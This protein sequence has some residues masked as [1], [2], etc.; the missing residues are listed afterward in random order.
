MI[1]LLFAC[2]VPSLYDFAFTL[3]DH[4]DFIN[5]CEQKLVGCGLIVKFALQV[6]N[7][8]LLFRYH[9]FVSF[10]YRWSEINL[11]TTASLLGCNFKRSLS[12]LFIPVISFIDA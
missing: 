4:L 6:I 3:M 12:F 5:F 2:Q 9:S 10:D 8:A 11:L 1:K 7:L